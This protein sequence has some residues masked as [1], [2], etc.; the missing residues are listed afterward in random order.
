MSG[1][2]VDNSDIR[3]AVSREFIP[4]FQPGFLIHLRLVQDF[5]Q[6]HYL[7]FSPYVCFGFLTVLFFHVLDF[8]DVC[9]CVCVYVFFTFFLN[10]E[11]DMQGIGAP[12]TC[13]E[14]RRKR[15]FLKTVRCK[16]TQEYIFM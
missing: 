12:C 2:V 3:A 4:I 9:V 11:V 7:V 13:L 8:T 6:Q 14:H 16:F 1:D 5:F 10:K 15:R